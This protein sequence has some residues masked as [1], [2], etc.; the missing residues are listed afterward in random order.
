M[1]SDGAF[2]ISQMTENHVSASSL[3]RDLL[4]G[5]PFSVIYTSGSMVFVHHFN[6][7]SLLYVQDSRFLEGKWPR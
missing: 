4:P 1:T 3:R 7:M 5:L 6:N 2:L